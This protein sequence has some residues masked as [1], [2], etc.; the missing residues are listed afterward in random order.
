[1]RGGGSDNLREM[2]ISAN[3]N[4]QGRLFEGLG[5]ELIKG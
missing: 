3:V 4:K 5:W 2:I 1:M